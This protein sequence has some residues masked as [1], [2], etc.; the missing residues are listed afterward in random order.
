MDW[1]LATLQPDFMALFWGHF[2]TP[3][4]SRD[5]RAIDDALARCERHFQ[6]LDDHLKTRKFLAGN[7]FTMGDIPAGTTLYRYFG[8]GVPVA[9]PTHV[10]AW[11]ERLQERPPFQGSIMIP[12]E[13]LRGRLEY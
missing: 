2:R 10:W 13:E 5:A 11:Y 1:S 9:K 12:F 3:E 6:I 7:E 8:M 4:G